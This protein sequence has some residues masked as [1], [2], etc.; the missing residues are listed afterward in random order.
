MPRLVSELAITLREY[1]SA[2][3]TLKRGILD[4]LRSE[5][6][7]LPK[8][9]NEQAQAAETHKKMARIATIL[10]YA[11]ALQQPSNQD[12][13][14]VLI[15]FKMPATFEP[16]FDALNNYFQFNPAKQQMRLKKPFAEIRPAIWELFQRAQ[17]E[18]LNKINTPKQYTSARN[19]LIRDLKLNNLP[20]LR[21]N[22]NIPFWQT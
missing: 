3:L 16:K 15:D 7:H 1:E 21:Q 2:N 12:Y 13:F 6:H 18:Q 22:S 17:E 8:E 14:N 5:I 4:S 9:I 11:A 20:S 19:A 10:N